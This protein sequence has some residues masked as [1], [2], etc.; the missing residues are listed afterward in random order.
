MVAVYVSHAEVC[1]ACEQTP[2]RAAT[3]PCT[4]LHSWACIV[5]EAVIGVFSPAPEARGSVVWRHLD[6]CFQ[7]LCKLC[8]RKN[9]EAAPGR[10]GVSV[11]MRSCLAVHQQ[12]VTRE[13]L[14]GTN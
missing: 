14:L 10:Y 11:A 3:G 2:A 1:V 5:K 13:A 12:A 9:G 7:F 8:G 4:P 6:S